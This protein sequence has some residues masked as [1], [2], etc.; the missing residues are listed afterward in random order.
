[1]I[2]GVMLL[3]LEV[4]PRYTGRSWREVSQIQAYSLIK[5]E[6]GG[7]ARPHKYIR[8]VP[9][10]GGGYRYYYSEAA[11]AHRVKA[12]ERI[13]IGEKG[14]IDVLE[15]KD[16]KLRVKDLDGEEKEITLDELHETMHSVYGAR[17]ERGAERVAKRFLTVMEDIP[18][19]DEQDPEKTYQQLAKRFEQ[20][21]VDTNQAKALVTYLAKRPGWESDAKQTFLG[22]ASDAANGE[23]I[24]D[25]GRQIIRGAE[26]LRDAEKAPAVKKEHVVRSAGARAAGKDETA[27]DRIAQLQKTAVAELSAAETAIGAVESAT[28]DEAM[29]EAMMDYAKKVVAFDSAKALQDAATAFPGMRE[30][31]ELDKLRKLEGRWQAHLAKHEKPDDDRP[32]VPGGKTLVFISDGK[33]NP[34]PQPARYRLVETEDVHASHDPTK[35]FGHNPAYPEG[36]Q[37]RAYHRDKAEQEKVLA[38]AQKLR[39]EFV[40]NTNPDAVNGP[41]IMTQDGIVLG[42]NSRTM[43]MQ[44]AHHQGKADAYKKH[45]AETAGHYGLTAGQVR[46]MDNP[47]LVRVVETGEHDDPSVLV[48]RYNESFTQ[49][50]DPRVDQVAKAR[51]LSDE[52][53]KTMANTIAGRTR[54]GEPKHPTLNA[55][56]SSSDAKPLVDALQ[57][58]DKQGRSVIDRRNRS[59]YIGKAGKLNEDGKTFVERVLVGHVIPHPE[60]LSD[61]PVRE[62]DAVARSVP[63]IMAASSH[64]HDLRDAFKEA[65]EVHG[66]MRRH[67]LKSLD[68][69]DA[70]Q[71]FGDV[72]AG[73]GFGAKPEVSEIG[74][75]VLGVLTHPKHGAG[76]PAK[77]AKVFRTFAKRA[78]HSPAGQRDIEGREKSTAELLHEVA[79]PPKAKQPGLMLSMPEVDRMERLWKSLEREPLCWTDEA[80]LLISELGG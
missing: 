60:V 76:K 31:P 69:F 8:R 40:A 52:M 24:S 19:L 49:A 41:P 63:H 75:E 45:L 32:G 5:A 3:R 74:R 51:L 33:G 27:A 1:M 57:R 80:E 6:G 61:M 68:E 79:N 55:Y 17:M 42:G 21:K 22:M 70:K 46:E 28:G 35:G 38:N 30:L 29:R 39:P 53:L 13:G 26:N 44:L 10:P 16:N 2:G 65:S 72:F 59:L 18:E 12:G 66:Y 4:L 64:G 11:A 7:A 36:V 77:M 23:R 50:M 20:A 67:N 14:V 62:M 43:S 71:E 47:V 56:L 54:E 15:V 9:K 73:A 58:P 25:V 78:S 34:K 48:R 37:E